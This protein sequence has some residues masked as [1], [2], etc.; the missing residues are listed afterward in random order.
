MIEGKEARSRIVA[1]N[2]GLVLQIARRYA[3]Q[4]RR[5]QEFSNAAGVGTILT[6][7]DMVQEGNLGLMEA[8]ERFDSQK[9]FRF[10]TYAVYWVRQ[11]ILRCI[12]DHSRI[13]RLPV[14]VHAL[15]RNINKEKAEMTREIGRTPSLPELAHRLEMPL[16]KLKLYTESSRTVLSLEVPISRNGGKSPSFNEDKRTLG[17][18]IAYEGPTPQE[19]AEFDALKRDIRAA[20][21]GL[22]SDRERDVLIS[23]FGLEDGS[24]TTLEQTAKKLG[25]SRD[26][27]RMV[28]ARALNKLRHPQRNYRLKEYVGE[29]PRVTKTNMARNTNQHQHKHQHHTHNFDKSTSTSTSFES[30]EECDIESN[31]LGN[32]ADALSCYSPEQIWSF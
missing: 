26:R 28:E 18:R 5:S 9:G 14:H 30:N 27:V 1:S 4:L 20:I 11:R 12:A 10:S 3:Y 8:A 32:H 19:D 7:Q 22:G 24:P 21:N 25:I 29:Q 23:R 6:L 17:E 16:E 15:L 2:V 31:T 13:I